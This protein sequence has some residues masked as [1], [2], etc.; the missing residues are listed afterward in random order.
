VRVTQLLHFIKEA[1]FGTV[2]VAV[3]CAL[4]QEQE[5]GFPGTE[6]LMVT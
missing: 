6:D 3:P 1:Q 5:A 2:D 4:V